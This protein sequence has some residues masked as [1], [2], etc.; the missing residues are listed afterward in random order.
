MLTD[1]RF[2][3]A[4]QDAI[5]NGQLFPSWADDNF[6]FGSIGIRFYPPLSIYILA[7]THLITNDW[8]IT[9]LSNLYVWMILGCAGM[10]FF[11][12]DWGTP[13]Q[14][15]LAA[16]LYAIVPQHLA[17]IFQ[18]FLFA[19]FAAWGFLPFCF[20]FV[21][22]ICRGG[23]W[24]DVALFALSYSLLILTHI[25]TTIIVSFS[26]PIYVLILLDWRSCKRIFIQLFSAIVLTLLATSF[27]WIT[28]VSEIN[29]L[30]HNGP[31]HTSGYY[32]FSLWMFPNV[33]A[34]RTLFIY[35]MRAWLFDIAIILTAALLIPAF[36]N[37]FKDFTKANKSIQ[38]IFVASLI[39]S[40][41][42]FFMLSRASFSIWN[43]FNF[44]QKIQYP[45]RWLS[46]FSLL[47]VVLFS[48]S[49]SY[50]MQKFEKFER[51]VAYPALALVVTIIL[52]NITQIIIPSAPFPSAEFAKIEKEVKTEPM[53]EGW[54]TVWA[55]A[56]AFEN[57]EKVVAGN[58]NV[59]ITNWTRE[60]KEFVVQ[61]GEEKNVGVQSFYYP[62]WKA[63]VNGQNIQINK[64]ENGAINIPI[65]NEVS[66]V[67]LYFEEPFIVRIAQVISTVTWLLAFSAM[68]FVYAR[69]YTQSF[70]NKPLFDKE[71]DYS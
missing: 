31:E 63:N 19:E 56:E 60:S 39:T 11:V 52:F 54:W 12:K 40:C 47:C 6:G 10:Y 24:V 15:L 7:I 28:I 55:K 27:R 44:L 41:F 34:S 70:S 37:L 13:T 51:L 45:W 22:R 9:F 66:R 46:V 71:Y 58:R 1:I 17:E 53:W 5:A 32:D 59:E 35:V 4:F 33:W 43:N 61:S 14:G 26:M 29:W 65:S 69:K 36:V 18:F 57:K 30:A 48:L 8:F 16:M 49:V 3:A 62:H 23:T 21:T 42:A 50:L 20:M 68:I 64:D 67:R 2:A 25:P 38:R